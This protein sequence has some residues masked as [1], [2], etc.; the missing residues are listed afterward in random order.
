MWEMD[1]DAFSDF[2]INELASIDIID[3]EQVV[4]STIIRVPKTYPSYFGTY[5]EFDLVKKF[6]IDIENLH[7]LGRNGMHKYNNM[8]HSMLT[9]MITVDNLVAGHDGKQKVW[10]INTEEDY[11]EK[12]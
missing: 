6:V 2:A 1:D 8:D 3:K 11:H 7:L 5:N 10:D 12:G 4:D 9:A